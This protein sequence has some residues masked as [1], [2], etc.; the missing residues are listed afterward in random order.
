[1]VEG[2]KTEIQGKLI[3]FHVFFIFCFSYC[4]REALLK[5]VFQIWTENTGDQDYALRPGLTLL[6][7]LGLP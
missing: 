6:I 4:R 5:N 3:A 7:P 1:M 2:W